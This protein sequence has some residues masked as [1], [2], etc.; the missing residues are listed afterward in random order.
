MIACEYGFESIAILLIEKG[1][2][3]TIVDNVNDLFLHQFNIL[4]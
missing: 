2:D 3:C 4:L 1:A